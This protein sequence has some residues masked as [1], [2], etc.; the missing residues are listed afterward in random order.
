MAG[1]TAAWALSAQDGVEVTVYEREWHLGGKGASV[2]GEHGRI[3]EHGLHVWL[4]YYENAFRL[5][6]EVYGELDRDRRCPIASVEDAFLPAGR[7]GVD[8]WVATFDGDG[9]LPGLGAEPSG[10]ASVL[11]LI[12]RG[13]RLLLDFSASLDEEREAP[14]VV[15]S[16]VAAPPRANA[17]DELMRMLRRAEIAGLVGAVESLRLVREGVPALRSLTPSLLGFLDRTREA[18]L[19]RFAHEPDAR[20]SWQLADM[21]GACVRGAIRDGLAA[22]PDTF[23]AIDHL[24][25]R[26]WLALHGASPETLDSPLLRG[27]YDLVFAYEDGDPERPRFAAGLGLFL[28]GKLFFDY[29]GAIFFKLRAGMGEVVFAPLFQALRARGVRFAFA[30]RVERLELDGDRLAAVVLAADPAGRDADPLTTVKGLP[31]FTA[32]PRPRPEQTLRLRAGEDFDAVVLATPL[33]VVPL[34]GGE[35][36]ATRPAWRE[37]TRRVATVPTQALQL[38]TR[39]G[40]RELGWRHPGA[41][42]S[43]YLAPFDTYASMSHLLDHEDWPDPVPSAVGYFCSALPDAAGERA[44]EANVEAFLDGPIRRVW[45]NFEPRQLVAG[46]ARANIEPSERYVQSLPGTGQYR[47][48]S[49]GS[50]CENL[51]LAGDWIDCGLNAGCMEAAVLSGLEAANAVRGRPLLEGVLGSWCEPRG[52][53]A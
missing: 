28:A 11:A 45:P 43:G 13:L 18:L 17:A 29:K 6:R 21:I 27:M 7:V 52:R 49:D 33:G 1:L 8:D 44:V 25:F 38:W 30:H 9:R 50:G 23:A 3:E 48:A 40:E 36:I 51:F 16:A 20:R 19:A 22:S 24:D 47:L 39:V 42:V 37:L 46:Y 41:T 15:I 35:L 34:L 10:P 26:E 32:R 2:R 12:Q 53:A 5:M 4:G 31:C 14:K